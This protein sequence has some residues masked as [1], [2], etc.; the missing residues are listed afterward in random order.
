ALD[1]AACDLRLEILRVLDRATLECLADLDDAVAA[2]L[3]IDL[4]L[5]ARRGDGAL[6]RAASESDAALTRSLRR[7]TSAR[8]S[9]T[10]GGRLEHG[11]KSRLLELPQPKLERID[12]R[13]R[14][15]LVHETLACEDV[16]GRCE[17]AVGALSK[18]R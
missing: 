10:L 4:D 16:R 9:E 12:I 17:R 6:L 7:F 18:R 3:V 5:D 2:V 14:G 1:D 13:L 8:P 11:A 15:E